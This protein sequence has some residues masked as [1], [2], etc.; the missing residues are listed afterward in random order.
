[1]TGSRAC[2]DDPSEA[3]ECSDG[4]DNDGDGSVD[5]DGGGTGIADDSCRGVA[6]NGA[7]VVAGGG[8]ACGLGPE[9][10][11]LLPLLSALR[12]RTR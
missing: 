3:P 6:S 7:E 11:L 10:A 4:R 1:L 2:A 5:A 8:F 9:L 12:R